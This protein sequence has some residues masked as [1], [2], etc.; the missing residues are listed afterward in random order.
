MYRFIDEC[1]SF[2]LENPELTSYLYFPLAN[3]SGMKS[4][5]TPTLN[6]DAKTSQNTFLLEPV[7]S[8]NLHNN[9][10]SRNFWLRINNQEVWS[11]TGASAKQQ[12]KLFSYD[13]DETS[14]KAGMMWHELTRVSKVHHLKAKVTSFVPALGGQVELMIVEVEN[15]GEESIGLT[16][17][18]SIPLY[19]RSADN[20]RDHRNVTAMLHR[21]EVGEEGVYVNPT[22]TFDERGHK[23]NEVVYGVVGGSDQEK[24]KCFYPAV[25]SFVGEG[26]SFE[27]PRAVICHD[28]ESV[29]AGYK[30]AGYEAIGALEFESI[31]LEAGKSKCYVVVIGIAESKESLEK[32]ARKYLSIKEAYRALEETKSYWQE[33]L[34]ISYCSGDKSFDGFMKWVSFQPMLRRIY[35]CSFLPHH[36]YGKGGRGWR[37]L[38]QDCLAL[39][40][41]NPT[42]VREMLFDNFA[43]VRI[44][45]TNATIIGSKQGEFIADRN[46]ITRVWMDHGAWPF[47]TTRLYILQSGDLDLLLKK[48]TYFKDTQISRGEEKDALWQVSDGN[49]QKTQQEARVYKG[50]LLE[51]M[52]LQHLTAFYDV[53]D[54]NDMRL[55]GADWN[56]ALDMASKRGESVAFT[57]LYAGNLN[58]MAQL[59]ADLREKKDIYQ[60]ELAEEMVLLLTED[61]KLYDYPTKKK[62][63]LKTYCDRVKHHISGKTIN[64]ESK[65]LERELKQ[66]AQWI[67]R[68]IRKTEWL[69]NKEG[70]AW[71]NGYYDDHGRKVEG[72]FEESVRVMLTG[73]V[74]SIMAEV[75][76]DVQVREIVK[77]VD[78]YLYDESVG[79]YRLNTNFNELKTDLG[80][81]FGFAYGQKENGAVF[82]HMTIMYAYALYER[83]FYKEGYKA[84]HSLYKH[85]QDFTKSRIYPGIPEYIDPSGRGVY[86]YLTG[87]ASWLL[88][89]VLSKMFGV[90]GY[91][92]DLL[93]EPHLLLEQ[94]DHN[95]KASVETIFNSIKL[96]IIYHNLHEQEVGDY[97]INKATLNGKTLELTGE[98]LL[99]K[100]ELLETLDKEQVQIIE[101]ILI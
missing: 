83:G 1:G 64:I 13:K 5:V 4:C 3:E 11:V 19:A 8:E 21:I 89:T 25:E 96:N 76:T 66:K 29:H 51:H 38:W 24:P 94:F 40:V 72:D 68:H 46:H 93:L 39:M 47:I 62:A 17:M 90:K 86:H 28:V 10:S 67:I 32:E 12:S 85:C 53:G 74:F 78:H 71:F 63:I 9:K 34:N 92:G 57:A 37:D 41:M 42:G 88:L 84:I 22:L 55:R 36:D 26:G 6:G 80:R 100:K 54:H 44:D 33:K 61:L 45:G 70:Y 99:I 31:T 73:Q 2:Y 65:V 20:L 50:T 30:D 35:G 7:S 15:I 97:K 23:M 18:A 56:D 69:I 59:I 87:S 98:A 81:M 82:S 14:L 60:I 43:G 58:Q 95:G 27:N 91:Y 77:T 49:L 16:P 75:A 52:L 48:Q 79:G 101:V